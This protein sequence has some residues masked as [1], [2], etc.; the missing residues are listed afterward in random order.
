MHVNKYVPHY[1][2][3]MKIKKKDLIKFQEDY[4][5]DN[6]KPIIQQIIDFD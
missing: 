3:M 1:Q 6:N 4:E 5:I 2:R